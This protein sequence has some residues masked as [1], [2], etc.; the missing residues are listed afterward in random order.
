MPISSLIVRTRSERTREV[1]ESLKALKEVL[2]S[3]IHGENIII[4]TETP[5]QSYDK[6]LWDKIEKI[7]GVLQCDLIYHNFEDGPV[8]AEGEGG[9]THV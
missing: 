3:E 1:A 4:L 9:K 6:N 5:Q 7:S 2:V 8:G